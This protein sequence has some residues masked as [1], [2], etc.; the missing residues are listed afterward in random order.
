MTRFKT[1]QLFAV[2]VLS[3]GTTWHAITYQLGHNTPEVGVALR[4]G[5]KPRRRLAPLC[6]PLGSRV[7]FRAGQEAVV[8]VRRAVRFVHGARSPAE[9]AS[10]FG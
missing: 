3:W 2:C 4:F 7:S 1:W 5:A 10:A 9:A 8:V 6:C